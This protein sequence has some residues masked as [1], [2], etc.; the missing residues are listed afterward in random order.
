MYFF[1]I[2]EQRRILDEFYLSLNNGGIIILN[3]PFFNVFSGIHDKAVGI[4][5]RF[6]TKTV[7]DIIDKNINRNAVK[8]AIFML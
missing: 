2:V 3:L 4:E 1:D 8:L 7:D 5:N 6:N